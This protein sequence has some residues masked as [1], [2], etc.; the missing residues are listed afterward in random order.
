MPRTL[1]EGNLSVIPLESKGREDKIFKIMSPNDLSPPEVYHSQEHQ[2]RDLAV[3]VLT[4]GV[5][6]TAYDLQWLLVLSFCC[7]PT[8][9]ELHVTVVIAIQSSVLGSHVLIYSQRGG[10]GDAERTIKA[11]L[12]QRM[13]RQKA[14]SEQRKPSGGGAAIYRLHCRLSGDILALQVAQ[15]TVNDSNKYTVSLNWMKMESFLCTIFV[16]FICN[17]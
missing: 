14:I 9:I 15:D 1:R 3:N 16:F 6:A 10:R 17:E 7:V 11:S 5:Q 12:S 2:P 13:H 4:L 8:L